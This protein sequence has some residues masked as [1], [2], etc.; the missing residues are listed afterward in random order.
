[1]LFRFH[2]SLEY[3]SNGCD[4]RVGIAL[5]DREKSFHSELSIV[6]RKPKKE[7]ITFR[8]WWNAHQHHTRSP[9]FRAAIVRGAKTHVRRHTLLRRHHQIRLLW[10][11]LCSGCL[12]QGDA[13]ETIFD[14]TRGRVPEN[15]T[16]N[17]P[18]P[19]RNQN[20]P[21]FRIYKSGSTIAHAAQ[22]KAGVLNRTYEILK[23][24]HNRWVQQTE[25]E[26]KAYHSHNYHRGAFP[27]PGR[28][29]DILR[30]GAVPRER[31]TAQ[32]IENKEKKMQ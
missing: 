28:S 16:K 27:R 26:S 32:N 18:P 12:V 21:Q 10:G 13:S 8:V 14:G 11:L 29:C 6:P 1:M 3:G 31:K 4:S 20:P 2:G 17:A 24:T 22:S 9:P 19:R 5:P 23:R 15:W 7:N 30:K 25:T